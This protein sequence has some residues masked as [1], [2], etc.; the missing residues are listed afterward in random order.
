MAFPTTE[1]LVK[2][3]IAPGANPVTPSEWVWVD[4]TE[5][6]RVDQGVTIEV[7]RADEGNQ[8]DASKCSLTVNNGA[9]KVANT[10]GTV[11]CYSPRNPSGPY[12]GS[13]RRGTPLRVG[14]QRGPDVF[15]RTS[16]SGW[17]TS[18]GGLVW[19]HT[20]T[21]SWSVTPGAGTVSLAANTAAFAIL[22]GATAADVDV[23]SCVSMSAVATGA[24][25]VSATVV[26]YTN[27][28]NHYRLHTE[29]GL[30]G[31]I[32]VK[33]TKTIGGVTS[34]LTSLSSA[35]TTYT[36]GQLI[37]T[38]AQAIGS[39]LR[40][41][42]WQ[43]GTDEPITWHAEADDTDL[44]GVGTDLT[45][46]GTGLYEW[47]VGGNTNV[48]IAP[49][50][51]EYTMEAIRY[52]GTVPE[53]PARWD[54]SSNDATAP[55]VASGILRRLQQGASPLRSPLTRQLLRYSPA[56]YWPLEDGENS[57]S[58]A[59]ALTGGSAAT[60]TDVTFAADDTLDGAGPV[61]KLNSTSSRVVA[62]MLGNADTPDGYAGMV[63]FKLAS[64]PGSTV[65]M[66]YLYSTGTV[67]RWTIAVTAI[68]IVVSGVQSDGTSV[69]SDTALYGV[70]PTDWV[71]IQ[72]E[73]EEAGGN[74]DWA[75]TWHQVGE[76]TFGGVSGTYAGTAQKLT[77]VTLAGAQDW[78]FGH[79]W[80]GDNDL[81][82]V[83]DSF[84]LVSSG[85]AGETASDRFARLCAE[86]GVPVLA[87]AADVDSEPM[88]IQRL[89]TFVNLLRA[90][91][92]ADQGVITER[93]AGLAY[94]PRAARYNLPVL[95]ALDFGSGHVADP[96]EP[97]DDD[98]RIRNDWTLT[99]DGG[100][101]VNVVDSDHVDEHGRYDASETVNV[102]TDDVLVDHASWRLHL[103]TWDELRWPSIT[104]DLAAKTTLIS[105]WCKVA[106][107]SRITIDNPPAQL[108]GTEIDLTVE[109]YTEV[110]SPYG[111]DVTVNCSPARAWDVAELDDEETA[112]DTDG[113]TLDSGISDSDTTLSV[114]T[115]SAAAGSPLWSTDPADFPT[116]GWIGAERVTVNS[117]TGSSSPQTWDVDRGIGGVALA[118][119]AG[120]EVRLWL[121]AHIA[122]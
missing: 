17:G 51:T 18:T 6:V 49:S 64:L 59:S 119:D 21:A 73:T 75:L 120:T 27:T 62:R 114:A 33:I 113:S 81:P 14:V 60:V 90:V 35:V 105:N 24:A 56:G 16:A 8:V 100:S 85:Y 61:L 82:F 68:A 40:I 10:L 106:P 101:T 70:D 43:D 3:Y 102:E 107:G 47:R 7:G 52:L 45:G 93:G 39:T 37:C 67:A 83:A 116:D 15:D 54:M 31:D 19:G 79:L 30:G 42:C 46:S 28:S 117:I 29:F 97:T 25:W 121:P 103:G 110:L 50:V 77:G 109:G 58:A 86:E 12:S 111:W 55:V 95:Q 87:Y 41:R 34:D 36:P 94:R 48:S 5:D 92:S 89:D 2:V 98:Q 53:W 13:L 72:L 112:L 65:Q 108:L 20:S 118:H 115:A 91:E 84:S 104:L 122:L 63:I 99:R 32:Q 76:T 88:G 26:R 23:E 11:G 78:A 4:I 1:L 22:A 44:T 9:S 38:R 66:A 57:R 71:A 69:V 80:L 74:V 96:P